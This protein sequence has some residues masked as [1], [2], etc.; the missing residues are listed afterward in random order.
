MN[1]DEAWQSIITG[2]QRFNRGRVLDLNFAVYCDRAGEI[3]VMRVTDKR[4]D[5]LNRDLRAKGCALYKNYVGTYNCLVELGDLTE[6]VEFVMS[7]HGE[8]VRR[9]DREY[10]H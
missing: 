1:L 3:K 9:K 6:D 4:G 10:L 5:A 2:P 8:T 7:K